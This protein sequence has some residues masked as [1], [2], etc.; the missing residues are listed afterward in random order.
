[1]GFSRSEFYNVWT[2]CELLACDKEHR[3]VTVSKSAAPISLPVPLLSMSAQTQAAE[4]FSASLRLRGARDNSEVR[5]PF[6]F[7]EEV[8]EECESEGL[9]KLAVLSAVFEREGIED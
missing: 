3:P 2:Y 6:V 5:V 4:S 7:S 1:M 9:G 8:G